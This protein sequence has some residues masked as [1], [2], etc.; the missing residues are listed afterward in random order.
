MSA[1]QE[2]AFDVDRYATALR[3]AAEVHAGQKVPGTDLPY[4]VHVV[5]VAV[6][7]LAATEG[8]ARTFRDLAVVCALLHDSVEDAAPTARAAVRDRIRVELGR[9]VLAGVDALTKNGELP[10]SERMRDSIGRIRAQPHAV[11]I[12]KLCDRLVNLDPPPRAWSAEKVRA[13]AIE[14]RE[15]LVALGEADS[16]LARRFEEKLRG[17]DSAARTDRPTR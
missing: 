16:A 1:E 10:K 7:T 2:R 17:Y 8:A 13:Y 15:I 4:L 6:E 12:V 11:W 14:A 9:D 3:L 5:R